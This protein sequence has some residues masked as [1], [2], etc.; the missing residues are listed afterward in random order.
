M[1]KIFKYRKKE[2][3]PKTEGAMNLV[4]EKGQVNL[5]ILKKN[6]QHIVERLSKKIEETAFAT[7]NLIKIT[8]DLADHV[9]V[10]MD[11]INK[12]INEIG[13]Y[14]ALAEEVYANTES[15]KQIAADTLNIASTGNDAVNNSINAMK[16]IEKS[17]VYAREVVDNLSKKAKQID[18]IIK[19]ING[20]AYNTNLL[21]LNASIEAARAGE[22]GRGFAVVAE[23][24]KKLADSSAKS[25]NEI[26]KVIKEIN[27]EVSNTIAAMNNSMEKIQEGTNI[28]EET[29]SVFDDIIRA[30]NATTKVSEEIN[31]AIAKQTE[32]LEYVISCTQD[33]TE[34]SN[35]V[36][37]LVDIAALN[38]QY[39]RTS[40]DTLSLASKDLMAISN[41]LLEAIVDDKEEDTV[42]NISINNKPL[43]F[44]PHLANDQDSAQ[45]L[46]NIYGALLYVGSTGEVSPGLAKNWHVEEDGLTWIF[47]LRKGAKFHNGRE[48][49]AEDVK[50]SYERMTSPSLGSPNTW[51]LD[52]IEGA[53]DYING[54]T[55][56][57][58]GVKVLD[59]YRLSIRL[60][61]PYSGFLLNLG[62]FT[63]AILAKEDVEKGKLT[64]CGP[65]I[66]EEVT[67]ESCVLRAF[68]DYYGGEP[69]I[70]K[71]IVNYRHDDLVEGIAE[72]KYDLITV[73]GKEDLD[74]IKI[75]PD[76][77]IGLGDVLGTYY[78]GFNLESNSILAR[79]R[80][81]RRAISIGIDRRRIIDNILGDL[82]EEA[83]G[84]IPPKIIDNSHLP[85]YVYNPTMAKEILNREGLLNGQKVKVIIRDEPENALFYRLSQYV[86][87]DL[88]KLGLDLEITKIPPRDYL[89]P[90]NIARCH[91]FIGRWIADTGD[92][93]NF[94]Q[95]IFNY[96]N[97]TNF[98]RY[99]NPRVVELMD[100]A[101]EIINPNKKV[102]IYKKIQNI[103]IEDCPWAPVFHPKTAIVTRK[104]IVGA[105]LSPLGIINYENILMESKG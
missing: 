82:G 89:R 56:E 25:A 51:F 67:D 70:D 40:L 5:G 20:I 91:I 101:K 87:E 39:A 93:D 60:V 27:D 48:I 42:L 16:E 28:A 96:D 81:A 55:N 15:S 11:S 98:T 68:K 105:R 19:V 50:Y 63:T 61:S 9:E 72:G 52:H 73:N 8:Y 84:P 78:V 88:Q 43:E 103:I 37:S 3:V 99:N 92:P 79:S 41:K 17:M 44:D 29:K 83:K 35:K 18:E 4:E 59:R 23:E 1:F 62:Q 36:I 86:I 12:V 54:R 71:I 85:G 95:P 76:V 77:N 7:D 10:Q 14:S 21:A 104:G 34:N 13:S 53:E 26:A 24:V 97:Q 90:E 49:T 102:E 38:T 57:I 64:G 80:E 69:F 45:I 74:R 32:S 2:Y 6:Q 46:M 22:V 94:L 30:V 31:T 100:E 58:S 66:L 33:M 47:T 65:Y 75:L